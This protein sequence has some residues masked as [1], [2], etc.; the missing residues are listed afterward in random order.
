MRE[1]AFVKL[2]AVSAAMW[3]VIGVFAGVVSFAKWLF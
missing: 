2:T 1:S 3:V